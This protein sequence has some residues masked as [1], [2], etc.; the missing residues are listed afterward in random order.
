MVYAL[1]PEGARRARAAARA[2]PRAA[3][4]GVDLVMWRPAP[5]EGAIRGAARRAAL[6]PGRRP[7]AT[8]A[9]RAGRVDGRRSRSSTRASRDGVL[10]TPDY[11]DALAPRVGGADAARRPATSCSR[12]APGLGVR[13]LGRRR[14]R[15][16]RQPRLAAPQRLARRARVLRRRP[17][18]RRPPAALVD[19]RRRADD[20]RALRRRRARL[21]GR[22]VRY[23]R[24]RCP[25][26]RPCAP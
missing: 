10:R 5:R 18:G 8:R 6:R 9:A 17:A 4:E 14:P 13:R 11:P 12:A 16:R 20:P 3:L 24:R 22:R 21:T 25:C 1:L 2:T 15:R 23:P 19:R 7:R 26:V